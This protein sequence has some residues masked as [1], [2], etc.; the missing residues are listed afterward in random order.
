M[1]RLRGGVLLTA[2]C[3][4]LYAGWKAHGGR[5]A[6]WAYGLALLAIALGTWRLTH[7]S[8]RPRA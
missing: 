4:A 7:H 6:L 5:Q 3:F 1:N 8:G 2:G